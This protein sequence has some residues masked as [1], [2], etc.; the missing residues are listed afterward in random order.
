V[1]RWG[2]A[3]ALSDDGDA[4]QRLIA[5]AIRCII[6]TG[7]SRIRIEDVAT[8]AGV[9]RGT[10]YRYFRGRDELL[11]GVVLSRLDHS[12][13]WVAESLTD[14]DDAAI[15]LQEFI[16]LSLTLWSGDPVNAA[17]LSSGSPL[18]ASLAVSAEPVID[19][20]RRH[21]GPLLERWQAA[22]QLQP[23]LDL[24]QAARWLNAVGVTLLTPP[25]RS[26]ST[27]QRQQFLE[28]FV[29][30]ALLVPPAG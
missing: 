8:E 21:L 14:P 12:L 1:Q 9:S 25:W 13:T 23:D 5:A 30:R 27:A 17:L 6:R 4:K 24:D 28:Q 29:L 10:V 11:L 22:G 18:S 16:L 20:V 19:G 3:S 15:G 26:M 2:T 7:S